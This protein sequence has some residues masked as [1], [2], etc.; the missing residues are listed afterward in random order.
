M[1]L[2]QKIAVLAVTGAALFAATPAMA[3]DMYGE[4]EGAKAWSYGTNASIAVSDTKADGDETYATY[5]RR[6]TDNHELRNKSGSGTTV[7]SGADATNYVR[8]LK[9]CQ[10]KDFQPDPCSAW[11]YR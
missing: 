6:T 8:A 7:Y 11:S 10:E 3:G 1:N 4:K 2:K 5:H 9:A